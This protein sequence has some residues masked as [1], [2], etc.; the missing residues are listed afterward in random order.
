MNSTRNKVGGKKTILPPS[1]EKTPHPLRYLV[2][3][4]FKIFLISNNWQKVVLKTTVSA[5]GRG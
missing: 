4:F 3:R 1:F 5:K 2:Y